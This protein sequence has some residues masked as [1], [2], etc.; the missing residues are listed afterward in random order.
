MALVL[1]KL[2]GHN[3]PTLY[4][5]KKIA[6]GGA[7]LPITTMLRHF[8][9]V[10]CVQYQNQKKGVCLFHNT[11]P[12][13]MPSRLRKIVFVGGYKTTHH[14]VPRNFEWNKADHCVI[15]SEFFR[16]I[17]KSRYK[18]KR[19]SVIQIV[20]GAHG[21]P[22]MMKPLLLKQDPLG[23]DIRFIIVAKW[24]K[25]FYKRLGAH[26]KLFLQYILPAY[27]KATL[28][29]FGTRI[30]KPIVKDGSILYYRKSTNS[31]ALSRAYKSSH[32]H[33]CLTPFDS[34]P[35]TLNE[36]MHYRI[37]FICGNNSCGDE[38]IQQ[39]DGKC[40]EV[41]QIDPQIENY[42]QCKK[43]KPM[44][45]KKFYNKKLDNSLIME[46]V[47]RVIQNYPVYTSWNWTNEFNYKAQSDKWMSVLF[48]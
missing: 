11:M 33:L 29:I 42:H 19:S 45:D 3:M 15:Q 13:G 26:K 39:V 34:G 27:P 23:E 31:D 21:D 40:G 41:V 8:H 28:H 22:D 2:K 12:S 47:N 48:G 43:Y 38:F 5:T 4:V 1:L 37:P 30:N 7:F 14:G 17:A 20:G 24:W 25:R 36:A 44:A 46:S 35:M 16:K 10:K 9:N 32:I 6:G 18:I